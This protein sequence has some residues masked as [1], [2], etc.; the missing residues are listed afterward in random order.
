MVSGRR[1]DRARLGG[2]WTGLFPAA[3]PELAQHGV[4]EEEPLV[5]GGVAAGIAPT[6]ARLGP[7]TPGLYQISIAETHGRSFETRSSNAPQDEAGVLYRE[8]TSC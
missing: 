8:I 1:Q 3:A 2:P 4:A 5:R 6:G 7:D